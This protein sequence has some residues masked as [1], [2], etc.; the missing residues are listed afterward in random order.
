M[1]SKAIF[2]VAKKTIYW[3]I[4]GFMIAMVTITFTATLMKYTKEV[5]TVPAQMKGEMVA[6]RFINI[7][8]CFAYQDPETNRVYPG[9]IELEKFTKEHL[10]ESC[11]RSLSIKE[12]NFKLKLGEREITTTNFFAGTRTVHLRPLSVLVKNGTKY[13]EEQLYITIQ[14]KI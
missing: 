12:V 11:Y 3:M 5:T 10:N 9:V 2:N 14:E 1:N 7:P 4:A 8:E 13:S 6:L